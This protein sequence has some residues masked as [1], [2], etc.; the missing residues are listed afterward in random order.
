MQKMLNVAK[1]R[2]FCQKTNKPLKI[3]DVLT[4]KVTK[5][6]EKFQQK[7]VFLKKIKFFVRKN[8]QKNK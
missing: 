6:K 8:K 1:K 4:Q 3:I 2:I 7:H 5:K